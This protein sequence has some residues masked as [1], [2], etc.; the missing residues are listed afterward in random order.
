MFGAAP[1]AQQP[2]Q[3]PQ[4]PPLHAAASV[5][6]IQGVQQAVQAGTPIDQAD[7]NGSSALHHA[8]KGGHAQLCQM[9]VQA[10]ANVNLQSSVGATPL[11][12]AAQTGH[13]GAVKQLLDLGAQSQIV[14]RKGKTALSVAQD[15]GHSSVI[16][17]LQGQQ[18]ATGQGMQA[19]APAF[20]SPSPLGG[21]SA[22]GGSSG[23][24]A[25]GSAPTGA[26]GTGAAAKAAAFGAPAAAGGAF[27]AT[28]SAGALSFGSMSFGATASS[29]A[30]TAPASS[31]FGAAASNPFGGLFGATPAA[32]PAAGAATSFGAAASN[33]FSPAAPAAAPATTSTVAF[34]SAAQAS[35]ASAPFGTFSQPPAP[36][37]APTA[38]PAPA[39]P[40]GGGA[41]SFCASS[42]A[43]SFGSAL[44][45][46]A[47][48]SPRAPAASPTA[49]VTP[50][51]GGGSATAGSGESGRGA[52]HISLPEPPSDS[53]SCL[54]F[55]RLPGPNSAHL[56]T[57]SAWDGTVRVWSVP[58]HA[59]GASKHLVTYT[60]ARPA[61]CAC[62]D[63]H[64]ATVFSGGADDAVRSLDVESERLSELGKHRAPVS[65]V[66]TDA[67]VD[68]RGVVV[69]AS[70]DK[71]AAVWDVRTPKKV[72]ELPLPERAYTLSLRYPDALLGTANPGELL[73]FDLRKMPPHPKACQQKEELKKHPMRSACLFPAGLYTAGT[74]F[75]CGTYD[76]RVGINFVPQ[77]T[78]AAPQLPANAT[79]QQQKQAAALA[80]WG[81]D[82]TFKC[83][84]EVLPQGA[85]PKPLTVYAVN[86]LAFNPKKPELL[87]TGGADGEV[88][89]WDIKAREIKTKLVSATAACGITSID[90]SSQADLLAYCHSDDWTKGE[91]RYTE[92]C[93]S[94]FRNEV[95]LVINPGS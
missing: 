66:A 53:I 33:P 93:N 11:V 78:A 30:A 18:P 92:L 87:A 81:T 61:L 57:A 79:P 65:C 74:G 59:Q 49:P 76:G 13:A 73:L 42:L 82:F 25:F 95:K 22:F 56:L 89:L 75:C 45:S 64:Q 5:G 46:V 4:L 21:G 55:A 54:R 80:K 70:W 15:K 72:H 52:Q 34:G 47:P 88:W 39:S 28:A 84:R 38:A 85:A 35:G 29:P 71:S 3:Q 27:S 83:H 40:G 31:G 20:G 86:T 8:A 50:T 37:P 9:L 68:L 23:G 6:D 44:P 58:P 51:G 7:A 19:A 60:H 41:S 26:F 91:Q 12:F 69:S 67:S 77:T 90:F 32:A 48:S 14:T 62:W 36:A 1:P 17:L 94:G 43:A 2:R 24:S 63:G 10:K 16:A